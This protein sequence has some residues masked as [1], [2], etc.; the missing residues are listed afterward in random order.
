MPV[1]W[2]KA[3]GSETRPANSIAIAPFLAV[4]LISHA[5]RPS[6]GT[7]KA[8]VLSL[9]TRVLSSPISF[10]VDSGAEKSLIPL[11]A[12]PIS[13]L[14]PTDVHLRGVGGQPITTYGQCTL[15][16]AIPALRRAIPVNFIVTKSIPILGAD[17]LTATSLELHMSSRELRDPLTGLTARLDSF[18]SDTRQEVHV[19]NTSP[20]LIREFPSVT[21][22]VNYTAAP[23]CSVQ[24]VINTTGDPVSSKPR[25]LSPAKYEAVK[26][27]FDKL[28][29][30]GVIQPSSSPWSSP[31]HAVKKADG[32]W[33]PCGDYR[34]LNS[35]TKPDRYAIPNIQAFHHRLRGASIFTKLDL[36]KA[37]HF[38][39][40]APEDV[41][42]TAICTP[43]GSF[44]YL[45]MP[46]GL[47]NAT[48]TFQRFIDSLF[49]D[50]PFVLA[51]VDD[52]LVYSENSE[53][54]EDHV[55]QVFRRLSDNGLRI[56]PTKCEFSQPSVDFLGYSVQA[57]GIRPM[58]SRVL[59]LRQLPPPS[60][61]KGLR[62]ILGMFG[63]YQRC[64]PNF[65]SIVKPLRDLAN[66]EEFQWLPHHDQCLTELKDSLA[67]SVEL[68]FPNPEA[69]LTITSDAS[70]HA[71]G[72]CLHQ[73][74]NGISTPLCFFSRKLSA[75]E[76]KYS[77]FDRELLAIFASIKKWKDFLHGHTVT[78]FTDHRPIVG[79]F[80]SAKP[81]FS[82]RQQRQLSAITE[83]V[84][85]ILYVA[86]KDNVVADALSRPPSPTE[87]ACVMANLPDEDHIDS[88][89]PIDLPAIAASQ[90]SSDMD[91]SPYRSFGLDN[92]TTLFCEVSQPNPRPVIP[93]NM[94]NAI[95]K[96]MHDLSHPGCK[97]TFRLL[98]TR[99]FWPNMKADVY[100]WCAECQPCQQSK[101]GRH[102][103]KPISELPHP[104]QRFSTVHIDI[105]GPLPIPEID[106]MQRPR[107]LLTMIDAYSRW[108]EACPLTDITAETVAKSFLSTWISRFGPPL[109][110]ITDRG[111]QFRS[112][113]MSNMTQL[114][115][116]HHIR[117][118]AYN[119][120]AN[121]RI[122]R[123]HRSLKTALKARGK[124]WFDQ[125]PLVLFGLRIFPDD[126]N[127]SPFSI[128][129]GEQPLVPPIL[130]DDSEI[131]DLSTKMHKLFFPYSL[132]QRKKA[133]ATTTVSIP[134]SLS[135]CTHVWLRLDRVRA[136]LEAPY[137]GPYEVLR[138]NSDTFTL[139]IR[140]KPQVVS[141]NR[142]KPAKITSVS[143][144]SSSFDKQPDSPSLSDSPCRQRKRVSFSDRLTFF[145]L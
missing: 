62:R 27:E 23:P 138:R 53:Q 28:L 15:T 90:A 124:C 25:V 7:Y 73:V 139:L 143:A 14:S 31:L 121:G 96:S 144:V 42:K 20:S 41:P 18:Q 100:N 112:E 99:F 119:P 12:V 102:V 106:S 59:A 93:T 68:D 126:K 109:T 55:R 118:C 117:T 70:A 87:S 63:F 52:I 89:P 49:R 37:Y 54:H 97:A 140:D 131:T 134:Q 123:V 58:S 116:I 11:S 8:N 141:I 71:I 21:A 94:R 137:Q 145:H 22:P 6:H 132:P 125:L 74:V 79:A 51:Y 34:A 40:I 32:T 47:R 122:E 129:T 76:E 133:K 65:A 75:A 103:S 84:S 142:L 95:F 64:I 80:N 85:D 92:S 60:D 67:S 66:S 44:E 29:Q 61:N 110:L 127:T 5:Q 10:L 56:N 19:V 36:V 16:L 86:G 30:L 72:A 1:A 78:V 39:P 33:R 101:I 83:Y 24:H 107:Y 105:V 128:M 9:K 91:F 57:Q 88:V 3:I 46:F 50:L 120:R 45:R 136:P 77:T 111:T 130:T 4:K 35:K 69:T 81:R 114:L 48:S 113:L 104:T 43:W 17:F 108:I 82:D 98:N 38:I 2:A 13:L 26:A 135:D 115:G